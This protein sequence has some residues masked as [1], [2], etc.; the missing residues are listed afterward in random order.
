MTLLRWHGNPVELHPRPRCAHPPARPPTHS[1]PFC[2]YSLNLLQGAVAEGG[3]GVSIWDT[4]SR[5][6]G[7]TTNGDT[8]DVADDFYHRYQK[9]IELMGELGMRNVRISLSWPR[10]FPAGTGELNQVW[11]VGW[12]GGRV[13]G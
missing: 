1:A 9:D 8:G 7:K 4:F 12:T 11:G 2:C 13:A 6:P 3:R 5:T 10:L